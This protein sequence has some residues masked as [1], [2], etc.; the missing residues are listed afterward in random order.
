M[1]SRSLRSATER[2]DREGGRLDREPLS[3]KC[4]A[5]FSYFEDLGPRHTRIVQFPDSECEFV[6][7]N[8]P[9][10]LAFAGWD[11]DR[12]H[13]L[14]A[15]SYGTPLVFL[16]AFDGLF[17]DPESAPT[18]GSTSELAPSPDEPVPAHI[19]KRT[20]LNEAGPVYWRLGPDAV[21]H[22]MACIIAEIAFHSVLHHE[23]AHI[24]CGHVSRDNHEP[25]FIDDPGS[26][27]T[28]E[29]DA[30]IERTRRMREIEADW[31]GASLAR[32]I[33]RTVTKPPA[34]PSSGVRL[35]TTS[36]TSTESRSSIGTRHSKRR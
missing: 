35:N 29:D 11:R 25:F 28:V 18:I 5:A 16:E 10:L 34:W 12:N 24:L 36:P 2:I 8:N 22:Q 17:A 33:S 19:G 21:R 23:Y 26:E 14:V 7:L 13:P 6:W 4:G 15:V 9:S 3:G 1:E 31:V 20:R 30:D 27:V 32:R